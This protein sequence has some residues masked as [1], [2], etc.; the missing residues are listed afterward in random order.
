MP[1]QVSPGVNVTEISLVTSVPNL[2]TSTGA[3]A[4]PFSWGPVGKTL[5]VSNEIQLVEK[6]GRPNSNNFETFFSAANFLSYSNRVY[7]SRAAKTTGVSQSIQTVLLGNTT[8]IAYS[9]S[10]NIAAGR[11]IFGS[12]IPEGAT[13]VSTNNSS[14]SNTFNASTGVAASG[15]ITISG[16]PFVSGE[17]VVYTTSTGNTVIGGLTNGASYFVKNANSTVL[18]LANNDLGPA[19]AALGLTPG[20]S[21]T[22]HNLVRASDTRV[23]ISSNATSGSPSSSTLVTLNYND[24]SISYNAFANS[25]EI[26]DRTQTVVRNSDHY[27]T[28]TFPAGVEWVAKY[29]GDLGSSLKISVVDSADQYS[30]TLN[31][32]AIV[33]DG[34]TT[35]SSVTP[36]SAGISIALN[37]T[38]ANVFVANSGTLSVSA[39]SNVATA[40]KN[41][42][43]VGDF[44]E[45][46]NSSINRQKL[47]IKTISDSVTTSGNTVHFAV[48]FESTYNLSTA[49]T[50][51]SFVRY[52]EYSSVVGKAP[53]TSKSLS[54]VGSTAVDQ[55]SVVVIDEDG[56]ISG[57]PETVLETFVNLSRATD[58]K[59]SDGTSAYYKNAINDFSKYIWWAADRS[60]AASNTALNVTNST[61]TTP[62]TESLVGGRD[63]TTESSIAVADLASAWDVFA[64][65]TSIDVSLLIAGKPTGVNGVQMAN[66]IID[67][68]AEVRKDC[69]VF[70]S[71]TKSLVLNSFGS[72][73]SGIVGFRN[74]MRNSS[75]AVL[76]SGYK[77]QYDKYNDMYRWVPLN[78]D[79]AGLAARTDQVRD[80][81]FSPAGF[82]RGSIKNVIKLAW[83]PTKA[84]RD[85]LYTASVNPVVTFPGQ[86]TV[87]FGDKT[88]LNQGSAFDYINVRRLFITLEKTIATAANQLL[89]E[90][91]DEFT[92]LQFK[93]IV[94]PFLREVA[95]R[96]GITDFQVICDET[97]NPGEIIDAAKFVGDIYIKPARSIN[98]IQLNFV[99]VGTS[100]EFNEIV[101]QF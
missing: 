63:G 76:D 66:Y 98:F 39:A 2:S 50:A 3:V 23:V 95:G 36:G 52:W 24:A 6:Y 17:R 75:Y 33:A 68:I 7:V 71:P 26:I 22:G 32:F 14:I 100:V 46:G 58:A 69:V 88:L 87:L 12:G 89:F 92:R 8:V 18:Y 11:S 28:V 21:E 56:K 73:A 70:A 31:P 64:D 20:S 94:E 41:K 47:Q 30:S 9:T 99:G 29:P 91:N 77:Y 79:I 1:F 13:V 67:N 86:G 61:A 4:G 42:L 16:Q 84:D 65:S 19:S 93:N 5:L 81:W 80:P 48:T 49:F 83:N 43:V 60:G 90:F 74:S 15:Q 10:A 53:G 82:N 85:T 38:T 37:A 55:V 34:V 62:Y 44:I 72:E 25:A 101:G 54:D 78:G 40:I 96:R 27:E 97:N 57:T 45:V 59:N 35:N 51:N